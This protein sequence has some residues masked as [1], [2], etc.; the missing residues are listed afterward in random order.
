VLVQQRV[1]HVD[2]HDDADTL[3]VHMGV[4]IVLVALQRHDDRVSVCGHC[5]SMGS[6]QRP[7]HEEDK[8][9]SPAVST[10]PQALSHSRPLPGVSMPAL[11]R[12]RSA[13]PSKATASCTTRASTVPPPLPWARVRGSSDILQCPMISWCMA[14]VKWFQRVSTPL[15]MT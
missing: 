4:H 6:P 15:L 9:H 12:H 1:V 2:V 3:E 14:A 11:G 13:C 7:Q 8:E 5:C 10:I